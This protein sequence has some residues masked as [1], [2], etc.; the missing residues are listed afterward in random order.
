M[1]QETKLQ[2]WIPSALLGLIL[3]CSTN[4]SLA[5]DLILNTFDTADEL[6]AANNNWSGGSCTWDGTVD[7]GG[8]A[9]K[10]SL[11][12][13]CPYTSIGN[14]WQEVQVNRNVPWPYIDLSPYAYF[15]CDIKVDVANSY[16]A[17]DGNWSAVHPIIQWTWT[18]LADTQ[19]T[20]TNWQHI[21]VLLSPAP[22]LAQL[23]M[24]FH[25]SWGA[26]PTNTI[27]YWIDNIKLTVPPQPPMSIAIQ[28]ATPGMEINGTLISANNS[29]RQ[30][31]RTVDSYTWVGAASPVTYSMTVASAP[32]ATNCPEVDFFLVGNSPTPGG[33]V[34]W[35]ETNV[36]YLQIAYDGN[37]AAPAWNAQ[38]Y[39][40]TNADHNNSQYWGQKVA[41]VYHT[42]KVVGD[43]NVTFGTDGTV[44]LMV[45]DGTTNSGVFPA[46]A[47]AFFGNTA[48]PYIGIQ[49][50]GLHYPCVQ[51]SHFGITNSDS[52][53][54]DDS[55]ADL[56]NWNITVAGDPVGVL[57]HPVD[58]VYELTWL[59]PAAGFSLQQ[60]ADLTPPA[61][62][63][64]S[65]LAGVPT[66]ILVGDY[67]KAF[68]PLSS[69]PS[70]SS[71]YWQLIK[72]N[73]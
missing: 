56:F 58:T 26:A 4:I 63:S 28:P 48:F 64:D 59:G 36:V 42:P 67:K 70:T 2:R 18:Q 61:T 73:P 69:L 51:F 25:T 24:D 39:Y 10:G 11:H 55:F 12:V 34:D 7:A 47:T 65:G 22:Q 15:E 37:A 1:K 66:P 43:W 68:I 35:N 6:S 72:P 40:K 38:L 54:M 71:T 13:V 14:D 32:V 5:G 33:A 27:A 16:P 17:V 46:E 8:T 9:S 44:Q 3:A 45:P 19:I 41:S 49:P 52:V 53:L 62:W 30:Y 20:T 50:Y 23:V 29:Q 31:I 21:K 57:L 60:T